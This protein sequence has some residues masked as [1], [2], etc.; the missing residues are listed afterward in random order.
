MFSVLWHLLLWSLRRRRG[1]VVSGD[2]M[3]PLLRPGD[4]VLIN[5]TAAPKPGDVL[6]TR[7]PFRTDVDIIKRLRH[8]TE[9]GDLFVVGDNQADSTDSRTFGAISPGLLHGQVVLRLT[10]GLKTC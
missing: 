1:F 3:R 7:H 9:D 10:S 6:L 5:P 2:S 4:I 8:I